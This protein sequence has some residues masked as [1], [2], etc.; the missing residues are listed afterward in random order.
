MNPYQRAIELL[1]EAHCGVAHPS[2]EEAE[3]L[4]T[5]IRAHHDDKKQDAAEKAA[6]QTDEQVR[7]EQTEKE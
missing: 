6:G 7:S 2:R 5:E 4:L 1:L 3:S